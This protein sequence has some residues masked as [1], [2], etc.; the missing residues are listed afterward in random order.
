RDMESLLD[1]YDKMYEILCGEYGYPFELSRTDNREVLAV[2][3]RSKLCKVLVAEDNGSLVGFV[4]TSISK[5]DRRF[6]FKGQRVIGR[7]DD[8][9]VSGEARG[10]GLAQD[11]LEKAE[12][13]LREEGIEIVESYILDRNERSLRFHQKDG[14]QILSKRT[15][16]VL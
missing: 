3:M 11:L 5:L 6:T 10:S 4:H 8:I 2:Q 7:I 1:M 12:E 15:Y 14:F 16:K 13:W 9:Y